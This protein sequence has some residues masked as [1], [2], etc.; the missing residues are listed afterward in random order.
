V[1]VL[2]LSVILRFVSGSEG[3]EVKKA[4]IEGD[5]LIGKVGHSCGSGV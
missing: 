3:V 1:Y 2:V 4:V 5:C